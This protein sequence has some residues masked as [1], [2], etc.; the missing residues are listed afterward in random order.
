MPSLSVKDM[1]ELIRMINSYDEELQNTL[2]T[3]DN[4][5]EMERYIEGELANIE[6]MVGK[7]LVAY[8][9]V[10]TKSLP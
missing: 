5:E 8:N 10:F 2:E 7:L 3:Q 4:S 1:N 9:Q 6:V